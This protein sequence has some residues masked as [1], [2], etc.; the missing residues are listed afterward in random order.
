VGGDELCYGLIH[1]H[2]HWLSSALTDPVQL[3]DPPAV[4][5]RL[6]QVL[7][8]VTSDAF[9]LCASSVQPLLSREYSWITALLPRSA[10]TPGS[11][12]RVEGRGPS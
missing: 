7:I 3:L 9:M 8:I 6:V 12:P 11:L 4:D 10:A 5:P 2:S 1:Q